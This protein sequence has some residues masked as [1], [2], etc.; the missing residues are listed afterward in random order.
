MMTTT[1]ICKEVKEAEGM[2]ECV[3]TKRL[4]R[5]DLKKEIKTRTDEQHFLIL[6]FEDNSTVTLP[7]SWDVILVFCGTREKRYPLLKS[8][9]VDKVPIKRIKLMCERARNYLYLYL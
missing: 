7:S 8:A 2:I 1:T 5:I 6:T 9:I 3:L 4:I